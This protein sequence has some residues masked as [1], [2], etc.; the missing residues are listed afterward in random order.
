MCVSTESMQVWPRIEAYLLI[1]YLLP[2]YFWFHIYIY[3]YICVCV[4]V[5][6]CG[7][8]CVCVYSCVCMC[9]IRLYKLTLARGSGMENILISKIN[10][11]SCFVASNKI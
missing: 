8:V 6:V 1:I 7:W 5:C 2:E 9:I 10:L 11:F 3:I 4:C